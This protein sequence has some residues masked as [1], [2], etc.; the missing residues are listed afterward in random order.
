[1]IE[2]LISEY[3][4]L[5]NKTLI[6]NTA[7]NSMIM[8]YER[9]V[10]QKQSQYKSL[11]FFFMIFA[12][13]QRSFIKE[14]RSFINKEQTIINKKTYD[15]HLKKTELHKE[16]TH[17]IMFSTHEKEILT[18]NNHLRSINSL[19]DIIYKTKKAGDFALHE[20][21]E[22]ISSVNS[23]ESMETMDLI[24]S[25]KGISLMSTFSNSTASSD[26]SNAGEAINKFKT[27]L[28]SMKVAV[29][30]LKHDTGIEH[31]DFVFDLFFDNGFLDLLGSFMAL[32]AFSKA[33]DSLN[34]AKIK[35]SNVMSTVNKEYNEMLSRKTEQE[36][37]IKDF[38]NT[39]QVK[40]RIELKNNGIII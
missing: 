21:E 11:N 36:K 30:T 39:F 6:E 3:K 15:L 12:F 7:S 22:A 17:H 28:D 14:M 31:M 33:E 8:D 20:I 23:A 29:E 18:L 9:I 10:I 2:K 38:E 26:I 1:M 4:H 16:I 35:V 32:D 37:V 25:N 19:Y 13:K 40:A 5:D 24:S 27:H 34:D